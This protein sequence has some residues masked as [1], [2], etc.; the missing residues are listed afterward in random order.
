MY[1][2]K[3]FNEKLIIFRLYLI[4]IICQ[5]TNMSKII[6]KVLLKLNQNYTYVFLIKVLIQ[7]F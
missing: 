1:N 5:T 7:L 6:M 3:L 2:T 4:F